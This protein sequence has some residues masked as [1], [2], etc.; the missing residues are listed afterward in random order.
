MA[1]VIIMIRYDKCGERGRHWS[2]SMNLQASHGS[3]DN[4]IPNVSSC[5]Q[6]QLYGELGSYDRSRA[7][8]FITINHKESE[9]TSVPWHLFKYFWPE[10]LYMVTLELLA[11]GLLKYVFLY[12]SR[13]GICATIIQK[14]ISLHPACTGKHSRC[15]GKQCALIQKPTSKNKLI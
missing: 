11:I 14:F 8:T 12:Q 9:E 4:D 13:S 5:A 7:P 3:L 15:T 10:S 2:S 6:I 1:I